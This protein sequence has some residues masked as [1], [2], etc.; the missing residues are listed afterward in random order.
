MKFL[1]EDIN[2]LFYEK[3]KGV[4]KSDKKSKATTTENTETNESF[5]EAGKAKIGHFYDIKNTD[6]MHHTLSVFYEFY[7][8][9]F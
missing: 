1:N 4:K 3:R 5:V 2:N 7:P 8:I 6:N 9:F